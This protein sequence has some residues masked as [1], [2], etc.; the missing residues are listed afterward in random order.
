ML[1]C[2]HRAE[3]DVSPRGGERSICPSL[4]TDTY[5]LSACP[6]QTGLQYISLSSGQLLC[7]VAT[8]W[9]NFTLVNVAGSTP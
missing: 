9:G 6:N 8:R 2:L 3:G 1:R 7:T 4:P 5:L